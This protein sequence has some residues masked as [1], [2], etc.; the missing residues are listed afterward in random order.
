MGFIFSHLFSK[1][2]QKSTPIDKQCGSPALADILLGAESGPGRVHGK[3]WDSNAY[4]AT[5]SWIL[6]LS[7]KKNKDEIFFQDALLPSPTGMP[8]PSAGAS[9]AILMQNLKFKS[10]FQNLCSQS[11][12][13]FL[14]SSEHGPRHAPRSPLTTSKHRDM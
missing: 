9:K 3:S 7:S 8:F 4:S 14:I 10:H 5:T 6:G 11:R 13:D 12:R 1:R 2:R